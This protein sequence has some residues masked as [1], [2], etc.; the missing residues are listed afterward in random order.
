MNKF[1][2]P[3]ISDFPTSIHN[4]TWPW[5]YL[6]ESLPELMP[7]GKPWPKIT[8]VTPSY[9]QGEYIEE[10]IRS[11]LLQGYPNLEY[12]I[13]DGGSTDQT[14]EIIKKYETWVDYWISEPDKGQSHAIN[15]GFERASGEILAWINSDDFY[16]QGAFAHIAKQF[17]EVGEPMLLYGDC[18]EIDEHGVQTGHYSSPFEGLESLLIQKGFIPQPASFFSKAMLEDI[19]FLNESLRYA[20]DCDLWIRI[21]ECYMIRH[22][23]K[24]YASF[25]IHTGSKTGAELPLMLKEHREVVSKYWG[26]VNQLLYHKYCILARRSRARVFLQFSFRALSS[27]RVDTIGLVFK[28]VVTFP[29]VMFSRDFISILI[30]LITGRSLKSEG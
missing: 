26:E 10:T 8:V 24:T 4:N 9:N 5:G 17:I 22:I 30:R 18:D 14:V 25:R 1:S 28:A 20:M 15:K 6:A 7:N 21:A 11:V 27:S 29:L 3:S 12:I 2:F 19:G 16:A 23:P 13:M